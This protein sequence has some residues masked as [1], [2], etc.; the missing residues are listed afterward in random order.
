MVFLYL[1]FVAEANGGLQVTS[2]K[3]M[4]NIGLH[5]PTHQQIMTLIGKRT[6]LEPHR[7]SL[8]VIY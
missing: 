5:L 4:R 2:R 1:L 3:G 8:R 7:G 6:T